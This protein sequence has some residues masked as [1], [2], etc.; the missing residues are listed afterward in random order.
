MPYINPGG[1]CHRK[2]PGS[3]STFDK[4]SYRKILS[5]WRH[6]METFSALLAL[7]VG[8]S[9][10]PGEF[11]SQRPVTRSFGVFF[12]LRL[13][14]HLSKQSWGWWFETTLC[15]LWHHCNVQSRSRRIGSWTYR[16][17]LKLL[18]LHGSTVA[19]VPV[20]MSER[21]DNLKHQSRGFETSRDLTRLIRYWN[22]VE[23]LFS[24]RVDVLYKV[25]IPR[26]QCV[27]KPSATMAFIVQLFIGERFQRPVLRNDMVWGFLEWNQRLC[28]NHEKFA[29]TP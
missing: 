10:V 17:P 14:K 25:A 1:T 26:D 24:K 29:C 5:L 18:R 28:L 20:K 13:N 21:S 6:Q 3:V 19:E 27:T 7:C 23:F 9:P 22:G 4:M 16:I 12:D 11:P 2:W 8:N 15:S